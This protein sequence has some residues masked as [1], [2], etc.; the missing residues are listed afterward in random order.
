MVNIRFDIEKIICKQLLTD[1]TKED[2]R[3]IVNIFTWMNIDFF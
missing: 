3:T 1:E 2:I